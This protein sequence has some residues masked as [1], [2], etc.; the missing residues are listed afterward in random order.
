MVRRAGDRVSRGSIVALVFLGFLSRITEMVVLERW[1]T[2]HW[3]TID[4]CVANEHF[5]VDIRKVVYE[6]NWLMARKNP[7]RLVLKPGRVET[8]FGLVFAGS[9]WA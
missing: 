7:R 2:A 4:S 5:V 6:Q 8:I 9:P 1:A 3:T